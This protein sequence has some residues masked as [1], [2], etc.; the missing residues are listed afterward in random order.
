[1]SQM[2]K[3][4]ADFY[5]LPIEVLRAHEGSA[6]WVAADVVAGMLGYSSS[7]RVTELF[8]RHRDEFIDGEFTYAVME[9][10]GRGT[11]SQGRRRLIFSMR[12]VEHLA[13]LARTEVGRKVRRWAVDRMEAER[14]GGRF[15]TADQ[16]ARLE[17]RLVELAA[18][19]DR[20]ASL[21]GVSMDR[22]GDLIGVI[23][24]QASAAGKFLSWVSRHPLTADEEKVR[25]LAREMQ[26]RKKGQRFLVPP[27]DAPPVV[28]N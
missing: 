6:E 9:T 28:Q 4:V 18:D 11:R 3:V 14:A 24:I 15:V 8:R 17:A 5:G 16:L 27:P 23:D 2:M 26:Q 12:G 10:C 20:L 21:V 1:M 7:K 22:I 25:S 19:R 13:L